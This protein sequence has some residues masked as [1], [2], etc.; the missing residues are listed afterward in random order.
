M[1]VLFI[2]AFPFGGTPPPARQLSASPPCILWQGILAGHLWSCR[3]LLAGSWGLL[4]RSWSLPG[5]SWGPLGASWGALGGVLGPLGRLLGRL[6]GDQNVTK[7]TCQ[8]KV[9]FQTPKRRVAL[10]YGAPFWH[11]KS[12]KIGPKTHQNLRRFSGAKKLLFKSVLEP[13]WADLGAF[14]RPSWG[15]KYRCGIGR[16]SVW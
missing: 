6:R 13:S 5:R 10:A 16:R 14:W 4:R 11:P 2:I 8:K 12:T 3:A 7:I 15:S 1:F 9:N